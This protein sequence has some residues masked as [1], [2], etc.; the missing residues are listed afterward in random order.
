MSDCQY[1]QRHLITYING[2]GSARMRRRVSQHI[3]ACDACYAAYVRERTAAGRVAQEL[4]LFGTPHRTQLTSMWADVQAEL[5][6]PRSSRSKA[7]RYRWQH[8]LALVALVVLWALP[9]SLSWG[10]FVQTAPEP[11]TPALAPNSTPEGTNVSVLRV[12]ALEPGNPTEDAA[13]PTATSTPA[14]APIP[15]TLS[16]Q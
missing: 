8:G 15:E 10:A 4:T 13:P 5:A 11:A 9:W 6:A 3:Q 14:V 7:V 16:V 1:C 12:A 2:E